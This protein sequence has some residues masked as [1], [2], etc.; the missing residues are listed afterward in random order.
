MVKVLNSYECGI[1]FITKEFSR[2]EELLLVKGFGRSE[3][4]SYQGVADLIVDEDRSVFQKGKSKEMSLRGSTRSI[5]NV[6]LM[7]WFGAFL[8]VMEEPSPK[9]DITFT[10]V[11]KS[12]RI[13]T[14]RSNEKW[15]YEWVAGYLQSLI[16]E[17]IRLE[18]AIRLGKIEVKE[19]PKVQSKSKKKYSEVLSEVD[20]YLGI[21]EGDD[22]ENEIIEQ[23]I[24][25]LGI[26]LTNTFEECKKLEQMMNLSKE[27][28]DW[29]RMLKFEAELD[30]CRTRMLS[31]KKQMKS[32]EKKLNPKRRSIIRR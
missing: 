14:I 23:Q 3:R 26:K 1:K 12:N 9:I 16:E 19:E 15:C 11:T 18:R 30:K 24:D 27:Q 31:I 13:I 20:E 10:V 2:K 8:N 4:L 7:G 32:L 25:L 17:N 6:L 28:E 5:T 29:A 22:E 21:T